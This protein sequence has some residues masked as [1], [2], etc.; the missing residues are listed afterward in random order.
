MLKA[1][2]ALLVLLAAC[3]PSATIG[4]GPLLSLE[5]GT[6]VDLLVSGDGATAASSSL[7]GV[8]ATL[9]GSRLTIT[10]G[11]DVVRGAGLPVQGSISIS[12][13]TTILDELQLVVLPSFVNTCATRAIAWLEPRGSA[14]DE[15]NDRGLQLKNGALGD[16]RLCVSIANPPETGTELAVMV[17][18]AAPATVVAPTSQTAVETADRPPTA[19]FD[20]LRNA[21]VRGKFTVL[22]SILEDGVVVTTDAAVLEIGKPCDTGIEVVGV[23]PALPELVDT[24]LGVRV[25]HFPQTDLTPAPERV[26]LSARHDATGETGKD[27]MRLRCGGVLAP[28]SIEC[29]VADFELVVSPRIQSMATESVALSVA[30]IC[31][32]P[33]AAERIV[34]LPIKNTVDEWSFGSQA[35]VACWNE[36]ATDYVATSSMTGWQLWART[37]PAEFAVTPTASMAIGAQLLALGLG[38]TGQRFVLV[39]AG[40]GALQTI[41]M[42]TLDPAPL[43]TWI[44]T[45]TDYDLK[46]VAAFPDLDHVERLYLQRGTNLVELDFATQTERIVITNVNARALSIAKLG[47]G[48]ADAILV[49]ATAS[50][51]AQLSLQTCRCLGAT[52]VSCVPG[53]SATILDANEVLLAPSPQLGATATNSIDSMVVVV[54]DAAMESS[55]ASIIKDLPAS[56]TLVLRAIEASSTNVAVL[57]PSFGAEHVEPIAGSGTGIWRL[58]AESSTLSWVQV[59]PDLRELPNEVVVTRDSF[60]TQLVA[61]RG[62]PGTVVYLSRRAS[63]TSTVRRVE[64][65]QAVSGAWLP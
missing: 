8:T 49:Y 24:T 10:T 32:V 44:S 39:K 20:V 60:G 58:Q 64:T 65:M 41:A 25:W 11:C 15:P 31:N 63:G 23:P 37:P 56:G 16:A 28:A 43:P 59:D 55:R 33:P 51:P 61:C 17:S 3:S 1:V 46:T 5:E 62:Q 12:D 57:A 52:C 48:T 22:M 35:P 50:G 36:G 13:A 18:L 54:R 21:A 34:D 27:F 30:P 7:A 47:V 14:C 53:P 9:E 45:A 38:A 19:L 6:A 4:G 26:T 42:G 29:G 40:A 2:R